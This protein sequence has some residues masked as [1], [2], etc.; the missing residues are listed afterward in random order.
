MK[1]TITKIVATRPDGEFVA[2]FDSPK[3]AAAKLGLRPSAARSIYDCLC[4]KNQNDYAYGYNF[5]FHAFE[6][7]NWLVWYEFY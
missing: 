4:Y 2:L 3:D 6:F 5:N 7:N 1:K